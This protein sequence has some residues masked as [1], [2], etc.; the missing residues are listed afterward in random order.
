LLLQNAR[1]VLVRSSPSGGVVAKLADLGISRVVKQHSTHRT[2]NTVGTMS[3]MV[4]QGFEQQQQQQRTAGAFA[5]THMA[6]VP[7]EYHQHHLRWGCMCANIVNLA[8]MHLPLFLH[9][10]A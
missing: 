1:N 8:C 4:S 6:D 5:C 10:V 9:R 7:W 3:H 2:T